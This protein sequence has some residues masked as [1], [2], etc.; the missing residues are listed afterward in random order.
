MDKKEKDKIVKYNSDLNKSVLLAKLS[1]KEIDI[2]NAICIKL[3]ETRD[4]VT[5]ISYK[6]LKSLSNYNH[7]S[8]ERFLKDAENVCDNILTVRIKTKVDVNRIIG[9]S[10]FSQYELN[11]DKEELLIKLNDDFLYLF[12][13][14]QNNITAFDIEESCSLNS[15]YSKI[16]YKN[17]KESSVKNEY[18][19]DFLEFKEKMGISKMNSNNITDRVLK[20][21]ANELGKIFDGFQLIKEKKGRKI[22]KLRWTW[23]ESKDDPY[24]FFNDVFKF[25][26]VNF[27]HTI[28]CKIIE[29]Q[30]EIDKEEIKD[31]ITKAW[32]IIKNNKKIKSPP[33]LLSKAITNIGLKEFI[34]NSKELDHKIKS[35][36]ESA[37]REKKWEKEKSKYAKEE[38]NP[39]VLENFDS[40]S[41][42]VQQEIFRK[43]RNIYRETSGLDVVD[44]INNIFSKMILS[45]IINKL[46]IERENLMNKDGE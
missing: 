21:I 5:K 4:R 16:Q 44:N 42:K 17:F 23:K 46:L 13:N 26:N 32:E 35:N 3:K 1:S 27:T 7:K 14:F 11:D 45:P 9:T 28:Q 15:K 18:E 25:I 33:A 8:K 6:E 20:P 22:D 19:E 34:A 36:K 43:A 12:N 40:L 10:I 2:F 30:K 41:E 39:K 29:M 37:E 24:E 38:S 31:L